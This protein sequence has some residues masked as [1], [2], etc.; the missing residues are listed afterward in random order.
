[1]TFEECIKDQWLL[2]DGAMGTELQKR[3]LALGQKPELL[4]V[5]H[6]KVVREIH[7]A[8]VEGGAQVISTNTFGAS[9]YKLQGSKASVKEVIERGIALARQANPQFVALDLGPI[10]R[11]MA[12]MGDMTF[13]EAYEAYRCQI[14]YSHG[15]DLVLV[16]TL[17]DL[18][19]A[20]AA[21][22]AVQEH[23]DLPVVVSMTFQDDQR[24][25]TGLTPESFVYSLE[26]LGVTAL[27]VN[28]SL[29]PQA[30]KPIVDRIL[31]VASVPVIVQSNAGMPVV[32]EGS[33]VFDL[34]AS[35]FRDHVKTFIEAGVA[36]VGGCC[37][38]T[39]DHIEAMG[40]L[41]IPRVKMSQKKKIVLCSSSQV[42]D[43]EDFMVIGERL[44]PTGNKALQ[45]ALRAGNLDTCVAMAIQQVEAGAKLI[46]INV[47]LADLD[48]YQRMV[49]LVD[50]LAMA[51]EVPLQIDSSNV[52][53]LEGGLRRY[54]G[55]AVVNSVNAKATSMAKI[56]PLIK[57]YG[58]MVVC[59]TLDEN[60]IP[61]T[62]DQRVELA[63]KI[64]ETARTYGIA[65][66]N[67]IIDP[68]VLTVSAQQAEVFETLKAIKEIKR[69]YRVKTTL[70]ISN[71]SYGMPNRPLLTRTF[72][73]MAIA[74][75]LD[76]AIMDPLDTDLMQS[77]LAARVLI[78]QDRDGRA[79]IMGCKAQKLS[80]TRVKED[81]FFDK[82]LRGDKGAVQDQTRY[83][84]K[85]MTPMAI[86][87]EYL[88]PILDQVGQW[89]EDKRIFLPQ[90]MR[91]AETIGLAFDLLK[92][93]MDG[94]Q[95]LS[96]GKV[97]LATVEGDVHDIGKNLVKI[98]L[99]NYGFQVIDLGKDVRPETILEAV[100]HYGV[101]LVGLSALM[102]T[103][104]VS[105]AKTIDLLKAHDC[106]IRIF[107][108]GAVLTKDYAR[109][110]G[111][112]AYCKDGKASVAVAQDYYR[113]HNLSKS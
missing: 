24:T 61:Q 56:F 105:M 4:N 97:I 109:T 107:V 90:L 41:D 98:L 52:Q 7:D 22:L 102:T 27:G 84:M 101:G 112:D 48:E 51:V 99:E 10:G 60:G 57:K 113:S 5:S 82:V 103:T 32:V 42:S 67:L 93:S 58:A 87:D 81:S 30:L 69:R 85:S 14:Q 29:G 11:M 80:P 55:V 66:E 89:Y 106:K 3:G 111:A 65:E 79:Y 78:N 76:S 43:F 33:T 1:M 13:E 26:A 28:C 95:N 31:R 110:L 92:A 83:W 40:Q 71:V 104:V 35:A 46:D 47:G 96:K 17:S 68:L 62:S 63:K 39:P 9:P 72:L 37:G 88:I 38:T 18:N 64:I 23:T 8:Y 21:V 49:D 50:L 70:G 91:G 36:M 2:F 45:A 100:C 25:L 20:R 12:P 73:S 16:E 6:G 54:P 19:E 53:V 15:A 44:N 75:G 34:K 59:L 86:V 77:I 94:D 108:G 74:Q